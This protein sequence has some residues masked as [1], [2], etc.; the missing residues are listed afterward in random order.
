MAIKWQD[1]RVG[2]TEIA[3]QIV[4]GK[5]NKKGNMWTDKSADKT[6]E[7]IYAV[8]DH[9]SRRIKKDENKTAYSIKFN[10]RQYRLQLTDEGEIKEEGN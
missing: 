2:C 7:V 1:I 10:G 3:N 5:I 4:L 8:T 6:N 9:M